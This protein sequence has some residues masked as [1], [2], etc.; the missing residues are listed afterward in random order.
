MNIIHSFKA[1]ISKD[2]RWFCA[3]LCFVIILSTTLTI[4]AC[5]VNHALYATGICKYLALDF[6]FNGIG[7]ALLLSFLWAF[8]V[9]YVL[10]KKMLFTTGVLFLITVVIISFHEANG[11]YARATVLSAVM[12]AQ[13]MAYLIQKFSPEFDLDKYRYQFSVQM[14]VAGYVLAGIAKLKDG[15]IGW[16]MSSDGFALQ[17][18]KNF[19][20]LYADTANVK[21]LATAQNVT[22]LFIAHP[23][24][25][26]SLL[27]V[28]L[29]LELFCFVVLLQPKI[30][31]WWGLCLLLMHLGIAFLMGIGISVIAF[32]MLIFFVNPLFVLFQLIKADRRL[33]S[34]FA[35]NQL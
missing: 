4:F 18:I 14:I 17:V 6:F 28:S 29:V 12:G 10:E 3:K 23:Y 7:K 25:P 8:S 33:G 5:S 9:L 30:T 34:T 11:I 13:F 19:N 21:Y 16:F 31:V 20:F 27:F 26:Q 24:I 1:I 15:G 32:P 35:K 2:A 22:S